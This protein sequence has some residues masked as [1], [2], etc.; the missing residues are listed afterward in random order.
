MPHTSRAQRW[1]RTTQHAVSQRARLRSSAK[2]RRL[3]HHLL[4]MNASPVL[5]LRL[6]RVSLS[7]DSDVTLWERE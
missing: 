2:G 7:K 1:R 3:E 5:R 4:H 6:H